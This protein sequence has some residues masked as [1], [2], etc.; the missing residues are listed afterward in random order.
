MIKDFERLS[1][2]EHLFMYRVPVMITILIAGAD[3]DIQKKETEAASRMTKLRS[4]MGDDELMAYY[5]EVNEAFEQTFQELL[6]GYPRDAG[7]RNPMI[8]EQLSLLNDI[9]PKLDPEFAASFYKSIKTF[10]RRV[11][12]SSGGVLGFASVSKEE[13]QWVELDMINDPAQAT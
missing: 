6:I 4:E 8:S 5:H 7:S 9:L 11:A 3:D 13:K 2:E 10:A 12:E 1:A